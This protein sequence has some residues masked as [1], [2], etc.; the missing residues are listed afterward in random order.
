M[1]QEERLHRQA[2]A[3]AQTALQQQK[4]GSGL[5]PVLHE[6]Q[7][8][9]LQPPLS[10]AGDLAE[11]YRRRAPLYT[12]FSDHIIDNNGAPEDSARAILEVM[13]EDPGH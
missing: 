9:G 2:G 12:C 5:G 1:Q 4:G 13:Y 11:M 7:T 3:S 8:L 6:A 10:Q